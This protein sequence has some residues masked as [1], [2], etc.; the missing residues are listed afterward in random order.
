VTLARPS[1]RNPQGE[2]YNLAPSELPLLW[3]SVMPTDAFGVRPG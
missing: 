1:P 2:M 3:L